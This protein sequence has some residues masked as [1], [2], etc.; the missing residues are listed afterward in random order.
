MRIHT[1]S[2]G[3]DPVTA[4]RFGREFAV[5]LRAMEIRLPFGPRRTGKFSE[6][7]RSF[8]SV[9]PANVHLLTIKRA[10]YGDENEFVIRLRE[11]AGKETT[12][13]IKLPVQI[14]DAQLCDILERPTVAKP[15]QQSP[16]TVSLKPFDIVT[17]KVR[18][19]SK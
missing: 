7:V 10:E 2:G 16:L 5:P 18:I 13:T 4:E 6:P 9:S 17:I 14:R 12:A 15:L 1:D 19:G 11:V 3:H 8:V